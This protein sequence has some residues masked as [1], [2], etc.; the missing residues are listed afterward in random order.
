VSF[1]ADKLTSTQTPEAF[2]ISYVSIRTDFLFVVF[3]TLSKE[4]EIAPLPHPTST[5]WNFS[6]L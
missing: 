1:N 3:I 5:K 6:S 2:G 4:S